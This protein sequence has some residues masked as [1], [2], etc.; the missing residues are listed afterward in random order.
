MLLGRNLVVHRGDSCLQSAGM[1]FDR[2]F[3]VFDP[4]IELRLPKNFLQRTAV[5]NKITFD[6]SKNKPKEERMKLVDCID[7]APCVDCA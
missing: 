5:L 7:S 1:T 4:Y 6:C 3:L 2:S